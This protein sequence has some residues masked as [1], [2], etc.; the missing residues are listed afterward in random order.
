MNGGA[1]FFDAQVD[2]PDRLNLSVL[3]SAAEAGAD[4]AN[5]VEMTEFLR[6]GPAVSGVRVRDTLSGAEFAIRARVVVNCTGPRPDQ[7]L[8]L[9]GRP[10]IE[11]PTKLL[12]AI[13]L[14]TRPVVGNTAVGIRSRAPY[15]D[16][17]AV[18]QKGYRFFFI[19]PWR[20]TSL[21]GTFETPYK[22]DRDGRDVSENEIT[23]FLRQI[24]DA[25]SGA[26][27]QREDVV[28]VLSGLLP[29]A[30]ASGPN[31]HVQ[32]QNHWIIRDH[33]AEDGISGLLSV[34]GVKYTTAR[35]IAERTVNLVLTK[36]GRKFVRSRT[37]ETPVAGAVI[38]G[39]DEFADQ[40]AKE[41][42]RQISTETLRHLLQC[43]GS[44]YR[45]IL[46]YCDEDSS[47]SRSISG[48]APTIR[49]EVLHGIR[50]EMARKLSDVIFR[51]TELGTAGHP[52][53]ACLHA[54][55]E[56]MRAELDWN[57]ATMFRELDDVQQAFSYERQ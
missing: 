1:L 27:L 40:A 45:T 22:A 2:N 14:V 44:E 37:A 7:I 6:D 31:G 30:D 29:A 41:R 28:G 42:T 11:I 57:K 38:N 49:A 8:H 54:C 18:V 52:G 25:F 5:Y 19:T 36:L 23:D 21:V 46:R 4:F 20:H 9:L 15:T 39:W 3:F 53:D 50:S 48:D 17:D 47:W 24:N 32:R 55:A 12:K 16:R 51:R 26:R 34:V 56:I 33:G 35:G 10:P 43:Y 13:V